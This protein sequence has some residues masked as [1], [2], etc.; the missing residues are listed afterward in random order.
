MFC[1][2]N[3]GLFRDVHGAGVGKMPIRW[4][5]STTIIAREIYVKIMETDR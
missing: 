2:D 5:Q 3:G 1:D 4:D